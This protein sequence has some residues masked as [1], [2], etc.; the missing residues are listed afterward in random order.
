LHTVR[1]I[2]IPISEVDNLE[3]AVGIGLEVIG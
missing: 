3:E 1:V 2:H